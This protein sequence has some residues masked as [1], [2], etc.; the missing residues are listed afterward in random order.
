MKSVNKISAS[1]LDKIE[2]DK[3]T[4]IE[5]KYLKYKLRFF[6]YVEKESRI[7]IKNFYNNGLIRVY[8]STS[9]NL[10]VCIFL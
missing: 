4:R 2:F 1:F 3:N 7:F 9:F 10:N 8:F 6:M 5:I